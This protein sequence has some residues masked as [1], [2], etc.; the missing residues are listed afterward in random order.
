MYVFLFCRETDKSRLFYFI[1]TNIGG[2]VPMYLVESFLPG[3][4]I[5]FINNLNTYIKKTKR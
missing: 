4:M 1:Q 3:K 2:N 5:N